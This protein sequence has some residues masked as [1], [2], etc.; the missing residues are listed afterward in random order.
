[1]PCTQWRSQKWK[2][3][4]LVTLLLPCSLPSFINGLQNFRG[5]L[6]GVL[7]SRGA[8]APSAPLDPPLCSRPY[9]FSSLSVIRPSTDPRLLQSRKLTLLWIVDCGRLPASLNISDHSG[10]TK[11][12]LSIAHWGFR[13][14]R[15]LLSFTDFL[16]MLSGIYSWSY[17]RKKIKTSWK[18]QIF[19]K[20][21]PDRDLLVIT[22]WLFSV[23]C[24]V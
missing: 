24:R 5:E 2:A 21:V 15:S 18:T 11:R 10:C 22:L 12:K 16:P 20:K 9:H 8:G 19:F 14:L 17:S 13:N 6:H 7:G 4:G 1:M 3:G 23:Q